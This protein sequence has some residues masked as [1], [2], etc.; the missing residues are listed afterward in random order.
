MGECK[1]VAEIASF[2]IQNSLRLDFPALIIGIRI[3]KT[4]VEA[5]MKVSTAMRA[6]FPPAGFPVDENFTATMVASLHGAIFP[7]DMNHNTS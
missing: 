7:F 1:K 4:A 5:A 2:L 6:G 3:V